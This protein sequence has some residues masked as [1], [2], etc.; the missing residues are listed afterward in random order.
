MLT[1]TDGRTVFIRQ[2]VYFSFSLYALANIN[3]VIVS[4]T[5]STAI[6]RKEKDAQKL[7]FVNLERMGT[8]HKPL[9]PSPSRI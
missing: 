3:V 4:Q 1:N 6:K 2:D 7:N 9:I 8:I 5:S